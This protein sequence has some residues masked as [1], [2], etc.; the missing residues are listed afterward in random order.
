MTVTGVFEAGKGHDLIYAL[1]RCPQQLV[2][3]GLQESK[4][5]SR[6]TSERPRT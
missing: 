2:E 6:E 1:K 3:N 4:S 5:R